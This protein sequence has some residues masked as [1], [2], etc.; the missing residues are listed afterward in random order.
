MAVLKINRITGATNNLVYLQT[1]D[2]TAV[3]T[4]ANY[5]ILQAA[6][7]AAINEGTWTWEPN[8]LIIISASDGVSLASINATFTSLSI[9]SSSANPFTLQYA[10]FTLTSAQW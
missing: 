5:L 3:A 1:S 2:T 8:D 6:N 7:I 4:A 9:V 10:S